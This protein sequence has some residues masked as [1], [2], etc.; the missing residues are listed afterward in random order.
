[1]IELSAEH[2]PERNEKEKKRKKALL[3]L[4]QSWTQ[5]KNEVERVR[6]EL[7][8]TPQNNSLGENAVHTGKIIKFAKGP[9]GIITL[10]AVIIVAS[11]LVLNRSKN[12]QPKIINNAN[13]QTTAPTSAVKYI[14]FS[15]KKLPVNQLHIGN[16]PDCAGGGVPHYHALNE[17]YVTALDGTQVPDPGVCG[18][19]KVSEVQVISE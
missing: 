15:G 16:G 1:V 2:L 6:A 7:G 8:Q 19:G 17:S 13:T 4:I 3:L 14:I 12:S 5:L 10:A 11:S 9:F 18:Y